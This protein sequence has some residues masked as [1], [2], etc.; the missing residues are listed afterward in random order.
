M[1]SNC[2]ASTQ[3][4]LKSLKNIYVVVLL[5]TITSSGSNTSNNINIMLLYIIISIYYIF[6]C[7]NLEVEC[8]YGTGDTVRDRIKLSS[9]PLLSVTNLCLYVIY[10]CPC[11]PHH[12]TD[13]NLWMVFGIEI[14]KKWVKEWKIILKGRIIFIQ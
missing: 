14:T 1:F 12:E 6:V 10:I 13:M 4:M 5:V 11:N 8:S 2:P 9:L 3:M 7:F